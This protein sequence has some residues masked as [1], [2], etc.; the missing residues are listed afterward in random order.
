MVEAKKKRLRKFHEHDEHAKK[1]N[2][3]VK[4][5]IGEKRPAGKLER[6]MQ[7]QKELN[8]VANVTKDFL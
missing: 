7:C 3:E 8:E 1:D 4:P 5:Q 6:E 2:Q